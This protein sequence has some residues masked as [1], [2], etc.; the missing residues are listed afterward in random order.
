LE[1]LA[2]HYRLDWF[3]IFNHDSNLG[4][5]VT[6]LTAVIQIRAAADDYSII[7]N[8]NLGMDVKFCS[9]LNLYASEDWKLLESPYLH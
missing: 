5:M 4:V 1:C 6:Q 3:G 9:S 7:G 8:E 2:A